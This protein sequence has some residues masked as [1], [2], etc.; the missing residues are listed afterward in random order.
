MCAGTGAVVFLADTGGKRPG[1]IRAVIFLA[2]GET[3]WLDG[4]DA[5]GPGAVLAVRDRGS[6][7][8][9]DV[10]L[11]GS[12]ALLSGNDDRPEGVAPGALGSRKQ[13][14]PVGLELALEPASQRL[15]LGRGTTAAGRVVLVR[16]AGSLAAGSVI[17]RIGGTAWSSTG[18]GGGPGARADGRARAVFQDGSALYLANGPETLAALVHN[19][20]IR[21]AAVR[22]FTV[23]NFS[24]HSAERGRPGR[25]VSWTGDGTSP[26][27]AVAQLRDAHQQVTVTAPNADGPGRLGWSCAPFVFVRSGVTGLGLV[28]RRARLA[29][30]ATAAEPADELPDPY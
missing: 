29:T 3:L 17:H 21:S 8:Q 11:S 16:G 20:R 14:V 4:A 7:G 27:G 30:A 13:R 2:S 23:P 28:E 12:A 1:L 10:R 15:T 9:Y 5:Y 24:G 26:S 18:A 19:T 25:R 22:D 6:A